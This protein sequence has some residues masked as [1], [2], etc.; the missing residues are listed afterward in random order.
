MS[1]SEDIEFRLLTKADT[2]GAEQTASALSKAGGEAKAVNDESARSAAELNQKF[3]DLRQRTEALKDETEEFRAS[4]EKSN[5]AL[6]LGRAAMTGVGAGGAVVAAIF[7]EIGD[8]INS[9]NV[10]NLRGLNAEM[11]KQVE[12]AQKW[13]QVISDPINGIQRLLSGTTLGDAFGAMNEQLQMNAENA[14]RTSKAIA[15]ARLKAA[16]DN[17]AQ[18]SKAYETETDALVKQKQELERI[19]ILRQTLSNLANEGLAQ[20]VTSA[21]IR[22]GDVELAKSNALAARLQ[23]GLE[24]LGG[25]LQ[26]AE[27]GRAT[28]QA[29]FD[30][31]LEQYTQGVK[32]GLQKLNP[33]LLAQLAANVDTARSQ[34]DSAD[35]TIAD[36]QAIFET[37]KANLLRGVENEL[38]ALETEG[39]Q[40]VSDA[41]QKVRDNVYEA[42]KE[43]VVKLGQDTSQAVNETFGQLRDNQERANEAIIQHSG[44]IMG[45]LKALVGAIGNQ[46]G[47]IQNLKAQ[48][49]SFQ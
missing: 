17:Q 20:E 25:A 31:A 47:E 16:T 9:I 8:S 12:D 3:D 37:A 43:E 35:Q 36:Q 26:Q 41:A 18:I 11:A 14:V 49:S 22:G 21:E 27:I 2:T 29:E 13:S 28:A 23:Q 24:E 33:D 5:T 45:L 38:A 15:D 42:L 19:I 46:G 44:D 6:N 7:K 48:I 1:N 4:Q 40:T 32:D 34:L 39:S 30:G 10:D